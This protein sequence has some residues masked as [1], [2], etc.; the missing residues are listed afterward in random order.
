M[1]RL[2]A[3]LGIP[4]VTAAIYAPS[5]GFGFLQLDDDRYVTENPGVLRG[6]AAESLAWAATAR[7]SSN[8]HP[9][10]LV[11]YMVDVELW[12]L[13]PAGYH[14]ENVAWHAL[15]ALLLF[16]GL[17]RLTSRFWP[18]ALAAALFAWHPLHVESVAWISE[19]K[20][21]LST[22]LGLLCVGAYAAY[23]RRGGI[24]RYALVAL[25]LGLGL[26]TKP[27]LVSWPFALLLLDLWP[28][29]RLRPPGTPPLAGAARAPAC[30]PRSLSRLL[31]EKVPLLGLSSLAAALTVA[32][33]GQALAVAPGVPLPQRVA[34]AI[35][36]V[37][38]Y[39]A[40]T[41]WPVDLSILYPHPYMP[42][43]VPWSAGA[44]VVAALLGIGITWLVASLRSRPYLLVGWLWFLGTL[45][46]VSGLLQ[47]GVQSMADRY[48]YVPHIG[49]FVA[50]AWG[51]ADVHA[52]L[53]RRSRLAAGVLIAV[54]LAALTASALRAADQVHAWSDDETLVRRSVTATP[55]SVWLRYKLGAILLD[56][57]AIR[58]ARAHLERAHA[59][60]PEW[61][62]PAQDLAW[63]LATAAEPAL[64]DPE[65]AVALAEEL[66]RRSSFVDANTL[67]TLATAYAAAGNWPRAVSTA[68]RAWELALAGGQKRLAL[69]VEGRLRLYEEGRASFH[70]GA[71][72]VPGP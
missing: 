54:V 60:W 34:N 1:L 51:I 13:E 33:Q 59:L 10:T 40:K 24:G 25:L 43:G 62:R 35:V 7:V 49:L 32:A 11:S 38:R 47:V 46:P 31:L 57:G 44:V 30:P 39:L 29:Q 2:L 17:R 36:A 65:R 45:V 9:L 27:M 69:E 5:V 15:N 12:G 22:S 8:W 14:A 52:A 72:A 53:R 61:D 66:A 18:S 26:A 70:T 19:R 41:L 48:T 21:V 4:L 58:E 68:R 64:R 42:G 23:A 56:R 37:P 28:L 6:I 20:D 16:L 63:L 55:D 50:A 67:D 71:E 3:V